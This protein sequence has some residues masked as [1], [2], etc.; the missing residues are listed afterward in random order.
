M[1]Q[2][3]KKLKTEGLFILFDNNLIVKLSF[4]IK[5]GITVTTNESIWGIQQEISLNL[6]L[7]Q[8]QIISD[9]NWMIQ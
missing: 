6:H 5:T 8:N 3:S 9:P 1:E 2:I 4:I 7:N